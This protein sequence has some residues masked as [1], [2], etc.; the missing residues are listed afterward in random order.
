MQRFLPLFYILVFFIALFLYIKL[1][2]PIPFEVNSIT[3]TKSDTFN[4]SGQGKVTAI[5]DLA[6]VN[7]GVTANGQTVKEAQD[8]LN[9]NINQVT[10]AIKKLG[11]DAKDIQTSS[12]NINPVRGDFS[13]G[14]SKITGYEANTNLS[15][16]VRQIEKANSVIDTA[17]ANGANQIGRV[18][19]EISDKSKLE[20]EARE[21]A[22]AE[23]KKKAE[24]AARIAGFRLG[25]IINYSEDF[26]GGPIPMPLRAE[27]AADKITPPTQVEPGS[28]EVVV[29]VILSF[30]I[31]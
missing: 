28:S 25:K 18:Q 2:G 26:M 8:K 29:N 12:Y 23:A 30:E 17:T 14:P 27:I 6:V 21:R 22:V 10:D 3:T 9:S 20:N 11:I 5:P 7:V 13:T 19:F 31:R 24:D 15:I 4:V 1:A 16:K